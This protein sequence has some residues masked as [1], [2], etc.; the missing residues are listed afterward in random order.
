LTWNKAI[1]F[2]ETCDNFP[3]LVRVTGALVPHH[4]EEMARP[5][6]IDIVV[7]LNA[8]VLDI[9]PSLEYI[10]NMLN[11]NDRLS[12]WWTPSHL[13]EL[14]YMSDHGRTV[15]TEKI[16]SM[17]DHLL[18]LTNHEPGLHKAAQVAKTNYCLFFHALDYS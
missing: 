2:T 14:T 12:I 11:P 4:A 6:G 9:S 3:V 5:T 10:V 15:A 18:K 8:P 1:H 7:V 16:V 17:K 13:L